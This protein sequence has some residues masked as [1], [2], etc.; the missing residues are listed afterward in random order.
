MPSPPPPPPSPPPPRS[1]LVV[2][3]FSEF[4]QDVERLLKFCAG[5]IAERW[6]VL[7]GLPGE[8]ALQ[9]VTWELKRK[10]AFTAL[11]AQRAG[12]YRVL[13]P[14][15]VPSRGP[16]ELAAGCCPALDG[17]D[18]RRLAG[19][20]AQN[21]IGGSRLSPSSCGRLWADFVALMCVARILAI[22]SRLLRFFDYLAS[23]E[24][25]L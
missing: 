16:S 4:S 11:R 24:V 10:W 19:P 5:K 9:S 18:S 23:T 15:E 8:E 7:I 3:M 17:A 6:A 2:G 21:V 13:P 22:F 25:R 14:R 1:C 12:P 20:S